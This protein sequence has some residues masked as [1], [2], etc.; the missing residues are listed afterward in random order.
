MPIA[1][2]AKRRVPD[3]RERNER[4]AKMED[5]RVFYKPGD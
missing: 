4:W 5:H 2:D 1:R 3:E